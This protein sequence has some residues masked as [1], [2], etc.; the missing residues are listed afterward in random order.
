MAVPSVVRSHYLQAMGDFIGR[1][2]R[3]LG[4]AG[5]DYQLLDT[6]QPLELALM[7]YLST[8]ARSL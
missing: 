7:A 3:E 5:I 1:Y 6:R 4:G 2:R 8:R